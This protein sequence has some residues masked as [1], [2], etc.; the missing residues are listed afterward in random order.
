M[1]QL[2]RLAL[3]TVQ[4]G[5]SSQTIAW[6]LM[7]LFARHSLQVQHFLAK[8]CFVPLD[9]ASVIT[10]LSSRH[11]DS[12]LMSPDICREIF[13]RGAANSELALV[14]GEFQP[15]Q[16]I[17]GCARVADV[18]AASGLDEPAAPPKMQ[19]G[20]LEQLC[21]WLALPRVAVVDVSRLCEGHFPDCP[22]CMDGVLLDGVAS[23][24][25]FYRLETVC[26]SLW[27]IP[28][29]GALERLAPLRKAIEQL[30]SGSTPPQ[31]LCRQLGEHFERFT[32][33]ERIRALAARKEFPEIP[34]G[35]FRPD[36][37]GRRLRIAVAYDAAFHCYFPD[38]LDL[39]E[40]RGAEVVDFSP[41]RDEGLPPQTD[42]VYLGCGHPERHTSELAR[43][44][45]MTAALRNHVCSGRRVYA[46]GGGLAYL[47]RQVELP[48]GA[49]LPMT[50]VLP[51]VARKN[52]RPPPPQPQEITLASG[53]WLA[54][55]GATLRGYRN[56]S[57]SLEPAGLLTGY[58]AQPGREHDLSGRHHAVGSLMHLNFAA[59]PGVL[60]SFLKP[61][62][63]SL[64][65]AH[66]RE[67]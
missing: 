19:G 54:E 6:A 47:C 28:V 46:E 41:L 14:E 61:H 39:L 49:R 13:V 17:Q 65:W 58:V 62:A 12:W 40:L 56:A 3:G 29:L 22:P 50:G 53:N 8:A 52:P 15:S 5:G 20:R 66:C 33:I 7:S 64:E 1:G 59:L 43:N 30:P 60:R 48:C 35:M 21:Q 51:A 26:H 31:D 55:S 36:T 45:C 34:L 2:P 42:I 24:A 38:T 27:R 9:G 10:G 63:A 11:L 37:L 23:E 25:E 67:P 4:S 18:N 16:A 32:S 44:L 57:W